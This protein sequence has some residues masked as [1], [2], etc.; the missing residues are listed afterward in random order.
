MRANGDGDMAGHVLL[1]YCVRGWRGGGET[2]LSTGILSVWTGAWH[3]IRPWTS[4]PLLS[5]YNGA[6]AHTLVC[7]LRD[8]I[9]ECRA[10]CHMGSLRAAIWVRRTSRYVASPFVR[11]A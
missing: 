5:E 11:D 9:A 8:H 7:T 1:R 6:I 3:F 10:R 4:V 2:G